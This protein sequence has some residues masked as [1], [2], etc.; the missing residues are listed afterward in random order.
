MLHNELRGHSLTIK[1]LVEPDHHGVAAPMRGPLSNCDQ[2]W[3]YLTVTVRNRI[4]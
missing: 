4:T 3:T 2:S 1:F